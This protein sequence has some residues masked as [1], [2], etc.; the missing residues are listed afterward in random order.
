M[1]QTSDIDF[2]Q[3]KVNNR[4]INVTDRTDLKVGSATMQ[5]LK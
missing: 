5:N 4:T 1:Y 2:A 3:V